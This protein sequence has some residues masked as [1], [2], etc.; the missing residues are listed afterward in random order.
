[1]TA[2]I[3]LQ[4]MW[5]STI[6]SGLLKSQKHNHISKVALGMKGFFGS[7]NGT[8]QPQQR[9]KQIFPPSRRC[10]AGDFPAPTPVFRASARLW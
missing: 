2:K 9:A 6:G 8:N 10:I 1:M 7:L 5:P 3:R 4:F